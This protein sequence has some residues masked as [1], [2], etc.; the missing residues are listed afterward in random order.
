MSVYK[1]VAGVWREES[2]REAH[3]VF[4]QGGQQH[5]LHGKDAPERPESSHCS[6]SLHK[7]INDLR[8][9]VDVKD[10]GPET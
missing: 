7:K 5:R 2:V 10:S 4:L 3:G 8:L 1:C 9:D 6:L